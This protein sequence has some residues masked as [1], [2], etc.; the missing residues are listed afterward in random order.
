MDDGGASR[1]SV[2]QIEIGTRREAA[3]ATKDGEM[4]NGK[5]SDDGNSLL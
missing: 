1:Q 3:T 4:I 5:G 2:N